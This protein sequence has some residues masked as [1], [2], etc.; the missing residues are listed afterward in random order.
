MRASSGEQALQV[1]DKEKVGCVFLDI[2]L[3]AMDGLEVFEELK[4]RNPDI[5]VVIITGKTESECRERA[6]QLGAL[7]Y[8]TKPLDLT[9]LKEVVE[10]YVL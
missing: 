7:D 1:Y 2:Q 4:K 10:R 6:K 8:L 9:K 5:K 3:Q